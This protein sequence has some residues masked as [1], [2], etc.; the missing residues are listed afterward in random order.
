MGVPVRYSANVNGREVITMSEAEQLLAHEISNMCEPTIARHCKVPLAQCQYDALSSFIF[1]VGPGAFANSTLLKLL[2]LGDYHGAAD[3]FLRWNKG[4]G[5]VL[6]G[7]VR[8]R[9][10]ERAMF[11]S[12]I[13]PVNDQAFLVVGEKGESVVKLQT[14]LNLHGESIQIDGIFGPHTEDAVKR[15]QAKSGLVSDGIVGPRTWEKLEEKS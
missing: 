1:N 6:A 9:A 5:R 3:Q 15:F 4:G 12:G 2:N 13:Q 14:S 11:I 10:E 7:L 8:R